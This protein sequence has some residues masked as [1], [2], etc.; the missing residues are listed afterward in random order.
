MG[1]AIP[2]SAEW[3]KLREKRVGAS[4]VAALFDADPFKIAA[5]VWAE[6]KGLIPP[7]TVT[8]GML[9]GQIFEAPIAELWSK[10]EGQRL[11]PHQD[12]I[13]MG[14]LVATIDYVMDDGAPFEV[15][16]SSTGYKPYWEFQVQTQMAAV[17]AQHAT[18]C[19]LDQS[20]LMPVTK[21]IAADA[22]MQEQIWQ[23]AEHFCSEV[24]PLDVWPGDLPYEL[25]LKLTE[26]NPEETVELNAQQYGLVE[27][28]HE[29][30]AA[31]KRAD[32]MEN[33]L[34]ETIGR[35]LGTATTASFQDRKVLT[36]NQNEPSQQFDSKGY[37]A[38]HPTAA[39]KWMTT[40]P[41]ARSIRITDAVLKEKA[42]NDAKE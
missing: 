7:A 24:L 2:G 42:K 30:R 13:I 11:R 8:G 31:K 37:R 16:T 3:R 6:K 39:K 15:K 38:A 22:S 5:E 17:K 4:E 25:F 19:W 18:I 26:A 28:L 40:K 36:F 14:P 20:S 32:D 23:T 41:G 10:M 21:T 1:K 35:I 27:K 9:R 29:V 33:E 12:S 34:K